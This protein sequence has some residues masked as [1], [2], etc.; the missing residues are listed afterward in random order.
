MIT[1]IRVGAHTSVTPEHFVL[2]TALRCAKNKL[3]HPQMVILSSTILSNSLS[4]G[5]YVINKPV[6]EDIQDAV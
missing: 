1:T 4:L 3:S 5:R 2:T 6:K